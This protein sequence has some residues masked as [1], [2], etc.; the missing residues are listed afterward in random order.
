MESQGPLGILHSNPLGVTCQSFFRCSAACSS[1]LPRTARGLVLS[2]LPCI[3]LRSNMAAK[4]ALRGYNDGLRHAHMT[5][6]IHPL[7]SAALWS[8]SS[9]GGLA[10]VD[11]ELL[12]SA[13]LIHAAMD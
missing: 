1:L 13:C 8:A 2:R 5:P 9:R 11:S 4:Q 3:A 10:N 12:L 6:S 7:I